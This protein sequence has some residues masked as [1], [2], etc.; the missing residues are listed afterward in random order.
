MPGSWCYDNQP[1]NCKRYGRLY[2]WEGARKAC[3]GLGPGWR[4]PSSQEW[5]ELIQQNGGEKGAYQRLI[6]GGGT[7]FDALLGGCTCA[8]LHDFG[9]K[10]EICKQCSQEIYLRKGETRRLDIHR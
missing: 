3:E 8:D 5:E 4:L 6:K 10:D 2:T 9:F 7:G 1:V